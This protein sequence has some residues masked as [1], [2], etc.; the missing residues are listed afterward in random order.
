MGRRG[1]RLLE[2]G[3]HR[4]RLIVRLGI[5]LPDGLPLRDVVEICVEAERLGYSD[6]WSYEVAGHDAFTPLAAIAARTKRLRLGTAVVP[7]ATRPPA[8][9]AMTSVALQ[10]LS[11]GR[12]CLGLGTSTTTIVNRWMGLPTRIGLGHM[13]GTIQSI[14]AI[15]AGEKVDGFRLEGG[16]SSV[17]I[18][19]GALGLRMVELAGEIA[20]GLILT[21]VTP[22]HVRVMLDRLG[23]SDLDVVLTVPVVLDEPEAREGVRE[24]LAAYGVIDVYNRHLVRQGFEEEARNLRE[25]W[26]RR[27]WKDAVGAVSDAMVESM[28]ICGDLAECREQIATFQRAGIKTLLLAP[29]TRVSDARAR[30]ARIVDDL[31]RLASLSNE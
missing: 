17:P 24:S 1:L 26:G 5:A 7:A 9:L 23:R 20:D 15:A 6:V 21:T 31:S 25:A 14:R 3:D 30:Q 4:L 2:H 22:A 10:S 16:A 12:F 13:R 28:A 11:N 29:V 18:Y 27:S 8:L 19:V